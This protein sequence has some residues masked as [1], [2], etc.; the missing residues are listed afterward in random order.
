[1]L[2]HLYVLHPQNIHECLTHLLCL[3]SIVLV[4][5]LFNYHPT[6]GHCVSQ[7]FDTCPTSITVLGTCQ[8]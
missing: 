1:M 3:T 6:C 4:F 2:M 7:M 8:T 5:N